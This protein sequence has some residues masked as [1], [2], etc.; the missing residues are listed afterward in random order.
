MNVRSA[1]AALIGAGVAACAAPIAGF[2]SEPA[3]TPPGPDF[4]A[5]LL[6]LKVPAKAETVR[7]STC[8]SRASRI[9]EAALRA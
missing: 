3:Y 2:W 7:N 9:V 5:S 6:L 8:M 4:G 1:L